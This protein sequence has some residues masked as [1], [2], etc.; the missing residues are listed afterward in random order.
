M[1]ELGLV[2]LLLQLIYKGLTLHC[3]DVR[4]H[5]LG[6]LAR[7]AQSGGASE[8]TGRTSDDGGFVLQTK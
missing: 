2:A 4:H 1:N 6:A 5:N 3:L 7:K 8:T